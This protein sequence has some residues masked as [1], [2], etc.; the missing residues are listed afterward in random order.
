MGNRLGGWRIM[1]EFLPA[2]K[3]SSGWRIMGEFLPAEKFS[4]VVP[5]LPT[6]RG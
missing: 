2:E 4:S 6:R 3:F 1:G 5:N